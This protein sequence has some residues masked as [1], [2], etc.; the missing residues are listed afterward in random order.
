[1]GCFIQNHSQEFKKKTQFFY[2]IQIYSLKKKAAILSCLF[3][4]IKLD[5][6]LV[7]LRKSLSY[8]YSINKKRV[9]RY[10][11]FVHY[12]MNTQKVTLWYWSLHG[13]HPHKSGVLFL[14]KIANQT[15]L[16]STKALFY[17]FLKF[18]KKIGDGEIVIKDN[19]VIERSPDDKAE[20]WAQ[21]FS[22]APQVLPY[23]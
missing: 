23:L 14:K 8:Y 11:F 5:F 4:F 9:Q 21:E 22:Q 18:V 7:H 16:N 15:L 19:E 12:G 17:Q 1:M 2:N 6:E 3:N 10:T 13:L 20:A